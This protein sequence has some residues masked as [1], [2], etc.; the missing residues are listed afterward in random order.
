MRGH[1][2]LIGIG[3]LAGE[4]GQLP[5]PSATQ[6]T[7]E[8]KARANFD[9]II[10]VALRE[11]AR[12]RPVLVQREL[13]PGR[14]PHQRLRHRPDL[15]HLRGRLRKE[16]LPVRFVAPKEGALAWMEGSASPRV[17]RTSTRPT[18]DQLVPHAGGGA[19]YSNHTCINT[20]AKGAE[21]HLATS[22]SSSSPKPIRPTRWHKLW[23]WPIQE[24]WYVSPQRV[25]GSLPG[26]VKGRRHPS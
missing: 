25:S 26:G 5:H 17:R 21:A 10:K 18:V 11:Q 12:G 1:S 3:L 8:K 15:G 2:G 19:L 24:P 6:F 13:G 7:D 9:A 20:M 14:F 22:T 4:P 23:W 16:D